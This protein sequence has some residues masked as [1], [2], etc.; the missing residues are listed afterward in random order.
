[1][2]SNVELMIPLPER[3][4]PG[5]YCFSQ[6]QIVT[7]MNSINEIS[8]NIQDISTH[9]TN[10]AIEQFEKEMRLQ[11]TDSEII[12][13][14]RVD[15]ALWNFHREHH[16]IRL[17]LVSSNQDHLALQGYSTL[18]VLTIVMEDAQKQISGSIPFCKLYEDWYGPDKLSRLLEWMY[19]NLKGEQ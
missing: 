1:M 4:D 16:D 17:K 8:Y 15:D 19:K 7:D 6:N 10:M 9:I 18:D 14:R 11:M 5:H 3:W 13:R 12:I 2:A